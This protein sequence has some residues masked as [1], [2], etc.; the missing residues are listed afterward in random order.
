[1]VKLKLYTHFIFPQHDPLMS[2]IPINRSKDISIIIILIIIMIIETNKHV[3]RHTL[4]F[5]KIN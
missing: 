3:T 2:P 4:T 1:V 5:Y